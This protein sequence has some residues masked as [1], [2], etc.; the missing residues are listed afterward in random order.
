MLLPVTDA[1]GSRGAIRARIA[2]TVSVWCRIWGLAVP[3]ST[4]GKLLTG[5]ALS[6]LAP[7]GDAILVLQSLAGSWLSA[8]LGHSLGLQD[9][10]SKPK[11]KTGDY[12]AEQACGTERRRPGKNFRSRWAW[13]G[14]SGLFFFFLRTISESGTSAVTGSTGAPV[15]VA[16]LCQCGN[17]PVFFPALG[18][19]RE[20]RRG[21]IYEL[22]AT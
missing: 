2:C 1:T 15:R 17:R 18:L 10:A 5:K 3:V 6:L 19:P 21:G 4:L 22:S 7:P 14:A 11:A 16:G 9:P 12:P 8:L 20:P 13:G